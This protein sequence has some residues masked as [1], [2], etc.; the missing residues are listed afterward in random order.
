EAGGE[1]HY[2]WDI[3]DRLPGAVAAVAFAAFANRL[4]TL[5]AEGRAEPV[6][7]GLN[8]LQQAYFVSRHTGGRRPWY[9]CQMYHSYELS[10]VDI[11]RLGAGG[12]EL[13]GEHDALRPTVTPDGEQLVLTAAPA[14]WSIPVIDLRGHPDPGEELRRLR[15]ELTG[16]GFPLD[17][18]PQFDL[19]V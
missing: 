10:T 3:A 5:A 7:R 6:R 12:A 14:A 19:R 8:P 9:G 2:R 4:A 17:R 15:D 16:T 11:P 18:W 1:L 13:M